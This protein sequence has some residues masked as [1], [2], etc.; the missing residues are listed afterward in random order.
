MLVVV[1]AVD[2]DDDGGDGVNVD[3]DDDGEVVSFND[4]CYFL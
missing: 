2:V 3:V 4:L 1:S